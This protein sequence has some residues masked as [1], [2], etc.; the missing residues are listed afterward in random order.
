MNIKLVIYMVIP[1]YMLLMM[2]LSAPETLPDDI[3][4][5]GIMRGFQK[6]AAFIYRRFLAKNRY[7]L[8]SF[9]RR[10]VQQ[11]LI[12]LHSKPDVRGELKSYYIRKISLTLFVITLG[13]I[14]ALLSSIAAGRSTSFDENGLLIRPDYQEGAATKELTA[15]GLNGIEYGDFELEIEERAY[16]KKEADELFKEMMGK[17][18]D[19]IRGE[20]ESLESVTEDLELVDKVPGY[21]FEIAWKSDDMDIIHSDGRVE[22]DNAPKNGV[23]VLLSANVTYLNMKWEQLFEIRVRPKRLTDYEYVQ[24]N[25]RDLIFDKEEKT[26]EDESFELPH[27]AEGVDL[28]WSEK[29][30]DNSLVLMILVLVAAVLIYVSKDR[31][32]SKEVEDRRQS[33]ILEYPQFVSRLV[34]YLGA[35]MSVRGIF[36]LFA[37]QYRQEMENGRKKSFLYSEIARSCHELESG[38]PEL[39]V[40]ERMAVR[41][42]AQQYTRLAT[43]LSQNLKKGNGELLKLLYEESDKA[44]TER[45]SI[46]RKLG[47]EAGTKLLVPMIMMLLIVMVIVV[48]PAYLSF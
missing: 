45:M 35:G 6:I 32:L 9:S 21:P 37:E 41:C 16:T 47:E 14:L 23:T 29:A 3:N 25:I 4:D 34:L 28:I 39:S 40:Y 17:L 31:E 8:R 33:M 1:L 11:D 18:P 5:E 46:A 43:L 42:G 12:T 20:N 2:L 36:R 27:S 15:K 7:F 44:T 48:V 24:K 38:L 13:A 26:R 10:K 19:I 30:E 22:S